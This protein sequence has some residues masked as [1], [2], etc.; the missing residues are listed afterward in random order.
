MES[1]APRRKLLDAVVDAAQR[2]AE[3]KNDL[4]LA[5]VAA[6]DGGVSVYE[7]REASGYRS[8]KSIYNV[9]ERMK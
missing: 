3:A 5:I 6:R 7:I 9:L 2:K 4:E 1:Q 8:N